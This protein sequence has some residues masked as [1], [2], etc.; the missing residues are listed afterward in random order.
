MELLDT[1]VDAV[2]LGA[3]GLLLYLSDRGLRRVL[4]EFRA[5]VRQELI[6][7]RREIGQLRSDL[8]RVALAVGVEPPGPPLRRA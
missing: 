6:E 2:V 3:V 7:L 5:E 4:A 8:T 1:V